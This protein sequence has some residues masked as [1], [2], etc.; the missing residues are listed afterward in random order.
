MAVVI[1]PF[2]SKGDMQLLRFFS[3]KN[4][5]ILLGKLIIHKGA[6]VGI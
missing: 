4:I 6:L 3:F 1:L 2:L 5:H